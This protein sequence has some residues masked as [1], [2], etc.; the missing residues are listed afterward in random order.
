MVI[1]T[2]KINA[3]FPPVSYIK[4]IDIWTGICLTFVFA[5]LLEGTL[6]DYISRDNHC[7]KVKNKYEDKQSASIINYTSK[8]TEPDKELNF[9]LVRRIF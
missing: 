7:N 9:A 1:Q 3:D 2:A 4:I 8:S 6:V 5:S